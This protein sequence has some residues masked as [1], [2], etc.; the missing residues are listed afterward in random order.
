[1]KGLFANLRVMA[2]VFIVALLLALANAQALPGSPPVINSVDID[3]DNP[4]KY[5]DLT[6]SVDVSDSDGD[7][8][9]VDFKW[10][11]NG[12]LTRENTRLVYGSS[13]STSDT[14]D[15]SYT[16]AYDYIVCQA[17]AYDFE[18]AYDFATHA[19]RVG[20]TP[21]NSMPT[22]SYVDITPRHPN[23]QQDLTCSVF[24]TD[25]DDNLDYVLFQWER[26][27]RIV[28]SAAKNMEGSS[29]L[30]TD[31]LGSGYTYPGDWI[32]CIANVY[33]AYGT[34]DSKYSLTAVISDQSSPQPG[35]QPAPPYPP[36]TPYTQN[37]KPI[38]ILTVNNYYVDADDMVYFSGVRSYDTDG[39]ILQY[40]FDY[41]DG[42]QSAWL[43]DSSPYSYHPYSEPGTYYAMVKVKDNENL[44]SSWS[45]PIVIRVNGYDG[46]GGRG[47]DP[48]IDD[49]DIFVDD[50]TSY[51]NFECWIDVFDRDG[52]LEYVK[53]KWYLNGELFTT[54]KVSVSG[55]SDETVSDINLA[56]DEY[57]TIKCEATVYDEEHNSVHASNSISGQ[58]EPGEGDGCEISVNRFDY[59]S[60][61]TEGQEGWVEIEVENTGE[62]SGTLT[63]ELY[64]DG[65][66][67]DEYTEYLSGGEK[68]EKRFEFPLPVGDHDIMV[69]SYLPCSEHVTKFTEM[70][71]FPVQ[72]QVFIPEEEEGEEPGITETNVFIG[73]TSLDIEVN[74]GKVLEVVIE[75]PELATFEISVDGLPEN[76]ANYPDEVEIEGRER[77]YV[78]IVPKEV[79]NYEFTVEVRTDGKT[80]EENIE[81]YVAPVSEE[82]EGELNG[83]TGLI[84]F[85]QS[86]WLIG[87]GIVFVMVFL[88]ALYFVSGRFKGK[89]YEEHVYGAPAGPVRS[90]PNYGEDFRNR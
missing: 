59:Y 5:N 11:V 83:L 19:V 8:D 6:C 82:E 23:P 16:E 37:K 45:N 27:G 46:Y 43:P 34:K 52:D 76:W 42:E 86:N 31:T 78:Y 66:L 84:S 26:N 40:K 54:E 21:A 13:D 47:H 65:S 39:Y 36:Y 35:P 44:E 71:V 88:A 85:T 69:E 25:S 56:V 48:E 38:A 81:L 79:G 9:Y 75:S 15:S 7:L 90:Y 1:M 2:L 67:E 41:G 51:I 80:F 55:R 4:T 49:I 32:K 58:F 57:Y 12:A 72:S 74:S 50:Y 61:L 18:R 10:Y 60:Y 28:R 63:I 53:F 33:D 87:L 24:A 3:P 14:L 89:T 20:S 73:P 29:D 70:T 22:V 68:A 17:R 62:R 30:A 64:V 77:V